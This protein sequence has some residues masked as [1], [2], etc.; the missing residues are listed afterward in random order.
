MRS[1]ICLSLI[2]IHTEMCLLAILL[3]CQ[4]S[5]PT[6]HLRKVKSKCE[7]Y[8]KNLCFSSIPSLY[9]VPEHTRPQCTVTTTSNNPETDVHGPTTRTSS[10]EPPSTRVSMPS[11]SFLPFKLY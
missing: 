10:S 2:Q 6:C 9:P 4:A 1:R 11:S 3:T 8:Y 7:Y 5:A